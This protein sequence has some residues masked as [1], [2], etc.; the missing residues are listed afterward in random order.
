MVDG[1]DTILAKAEHARVAEAIAA[2]EKGTSGEIYCVLAR[3]SDDYF[4]PA[5]F[6][7]SLLVM[8]LT[9]VAALALEWSWTPLRPLDVIAA[10]AAVLLAGLMGLKLFPGARL[11]LVPSRLRSRRA[12]DNAAKQFLAHNIHGT[13][14]RTGVLIFVSLAERHAEVVADAGIAAVV[15]QAAWDAVVADLVAEARAGRL[16][17][18]FVGAVAAVGALLAEHFPPLPGQIGELDDHLVEI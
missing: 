13:T 11:W 17:E 15:P 2:A 6:V 3:R 5:A 9:G 14:R 1:S 12:R 4:F 10:Q 18:G 8:A 7:L 16:A